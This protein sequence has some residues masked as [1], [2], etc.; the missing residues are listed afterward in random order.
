MRAVSR[1]LG[2][3][4]PNASLLSA[5]GRLYLACKEEGSRCVCG[6]V[7]AGTYAWMSNTKARIKQLE[8]V[9]RRARQREG[10]DGL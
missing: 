5:H 7:C 9:Q 2:R 6:V 3:E 8:M 10:V 4:D 1:A